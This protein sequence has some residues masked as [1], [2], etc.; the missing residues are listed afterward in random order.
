LIYPYS[1]LASLAHQ[2]MFHTLELVRLVQK[3]GLIQSGTQTRGML[4]ALRGTDG[5]RLKN[6][7]DNIGKG[8]YTFNTMQLTQLPS[9]LRPV[10]AVAG[11]GKS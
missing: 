11:A 7:G 5:V 10:T 1:K 3:S 4:D 6:C 8:L 9:E 2:S